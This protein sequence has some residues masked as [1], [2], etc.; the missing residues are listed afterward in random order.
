MMVAKQRELKT[1]AL[2]EIRAF[3]GGLKRNE[4]VKSL[5]PMLKLFAFERAS[6]WI[7]SGF[8]IVHVTVHFPF[9]VAKGVG[10]VAAGASDAVALA[11][12]IR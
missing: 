10:A 11:V 9:A 12:P 2:M 1:P 3:M 8:L 6:A 4:L 5:A 7:A